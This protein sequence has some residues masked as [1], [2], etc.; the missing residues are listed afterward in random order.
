[1]THRSPWKISAPSPAAGSRWRWG[2]RSAASRS[3]GLRSGRP[4]NPR[5][6]AGGPHAPE[7]LTLVPLR[8]PSRFTAEG[9]AH[10]APRGTA[11]DERRGAGGVTP[12]LREQAMPPGGGQAD[13]HR[14]TVLVAGNRASVVQKTPGRPGPAPATR[15]GARRGFPTRGNGDHE[16]RSRP[17]PD[18]TCTRPD[19]HRLDPGNPPTGQ[20]RSRCSGTAVQDPVHDGPGKEPTWGKLDR[21]S[22]KPPRSA[23][24]GPVSAGG[25][26]ARDGGG[27]PTRRADGHGEM[28]VPTHPWVRRTPGG[29]R[30]RIASAI[31]GHVDPAQTARREPR[32]VRPSSGRRRTAWTPRRKAPTANR[33]LS[34]G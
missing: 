8:C 34:K 23:V 15:L 22:G 5:L 19:G 11:P 6:G 16:G 2:F 30:T 13:A 10:D 24:A 25:S 12:F 21:Q 26:A 33:R 32:P 7:L 27:T 14:A 1:M 4:G 29:R 18:R 31:H 3:D 17:D 28:P 9:E 20:N